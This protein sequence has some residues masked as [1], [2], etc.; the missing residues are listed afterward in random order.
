MRPWRRSSC[1]QGLF[2]EELPSHQGGLSP[3]L[4]GLPWE[5]CSEVAGRATGNGGSFRRV[6]ASQRLLSPAQRRLR[7][8]WRPEVGGGVCVGGPLALSW[9][10]C[11]FTM[12]PRP[13]HHI[14]TDTVLQKM[15]LQRFWSVPEKIVGARTVH[16]RLLA[17]LA[18]DG[19]C[20]SS[21]SPTPPTIRPEGSSS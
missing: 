4:L 3:F 12:I 13:A 14:S 19:T 9:C 18:L 6:E 8:P 21:T 1:M 16:V 10:G 15:K 2:I 11:G 20:E 5:F 17:R 7:L